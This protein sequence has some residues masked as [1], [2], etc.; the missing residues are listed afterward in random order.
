MATILTNPSLE[1]IKQVIEENFHEYWGTKER[2]VKGSRIKF[3]ET[4]E[5]TITDSGIPFSMCNN[6]LK[7][8]L[9]TEQ[10]EKKVE[11]V[12]KYFEEKKLPF[13][14]H[15][16]SQTKPASLTDLLISKYNFSQVILPGMYLNI[17]QL[18]KG[19]EIK[20]LEIVKVE[21]KN[22]YEIWEDLLMTTFNFPEEIAKGYFLN[23]FEHKNEGDQ[24]A[25]IGYYKGKPV[26]I[27]LV[28]FKQ[29]VAG[30]YCVGTTKEARGKGI[31][32][33]ITYAAVKEAQERGYEIVI[34]HASKMGYNVYEK[35]GFN[36][37]CQINFLIWRPNQT[38]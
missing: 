38:S 27:S 10:L 15:T 26:A 9:P 24:T 5:Y 2:E 19:K 29:G 25:F 22:Q 16:G 13:I 12:I 18:E 23:F 7:T 3:I 14:W 37:V 17:T 8:N 20:D 21:E 1:R 36:E 35:M 4:E 32:T 34:L 31:G 28:C 11:E 30:I 33:A 6:V